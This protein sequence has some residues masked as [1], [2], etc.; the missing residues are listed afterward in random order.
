MKKKKRKKK[1][2]GDKLVTILLLAVLL[3]GASLLLYPTIADYW[4]SFHQ[5]RAIATLNKKVADLSKKDREKMWK[6]ARKYNKELR[7][8]PNRYRMTTAQKKEY[9]SL[10]DVTGTGIMGSIQI[11]KL[12]TEQAIYHGTSKGVLQKA[13]GHIEGSSLPVGGK[14]SHCVIS[15]HRGLPSARLFTDIDQLEE[16]DVFMLQVLGHTLTYQ[17]DQIR[18]VLPDQMQNLK[19]VDGKDYCTLVTCTP[20][21]VNT[22]RLLVRGKRIPNDDSENVTADA[23]QIDPM[24]AMPVIAVIILLALLIILL[25]TG[26]QKKKRKKYVSKLLQKDHEKLHM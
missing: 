8:T 11:P 9:R 5:T 16:G 2:K 14:G 18:I 15:G 3:I 7:H 10:L 21:G 23:M 1:R 24:Y 13:I 22:H 6:A 17:V 20:Y 25:I 12:H 4:N 26:R 19:I